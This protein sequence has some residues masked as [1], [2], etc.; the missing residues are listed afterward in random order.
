M[1][2]SSRIKFGFSASIIC[3][4]RVGSC[5]A[6]DVKPARCNTD[7]ISLTSAGE[8]STIRILVKRTNSGADIS[9]LSNAIGQPSSGKEGKPARN[10]C[11][12]FVINDLQ[13]LYLSA[14]RSLKRLQPD[15]YVSS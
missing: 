11:N 14:W 15:V 13:V 6:T 8:S 3:S 10:Q 1:T 5:T 7:C 12:A 2:T 4:S 9:A